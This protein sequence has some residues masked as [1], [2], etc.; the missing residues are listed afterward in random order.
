MIKKVDF[1][2]FSLLFLTIAII[3][4][5]LL[6]QYSYTNLSDHENRA[7]IPK[8]MSIIGT[9]PP[10]S[11]IWSITDY[12][13]VENE[14]IIVNGSIFI[15][16][17]GTLELRNTTLLMNLTSD[18]E[19]RI[20]VY[21][22]GNLTVIN[23]NITAYNITNNYYIKV[24][25]DAS[26]YVDSSEISYAGFG[27][28]VATGLLIYAN[29]TIIKNSYIHHN[30]VGIYLNANDSILINNILKNNTDSGIRL[31]NS[32][33]NIIENNSITNSTYG[34]FLSNSHNNSILRNKV[35]NAN[36]N[37]MYIYQS[38]N[39]TMSENIITN[40]SIYGIYLSQTWGN[41]IVKNTFLNNSPFG[42][43]IFYSKDISIFDNSI[44]NNSQHGIYLFRDTNVNISNNTLLWNKVSGVYLGYSNRSIISENIIKHNSYGVYLYHAN[45][46][47]ITKNVAYYNTIYGI[48]LYGSC[49]RNTIYENNVSWSSYG[50]Y[51]R[52]AENNTIVKNRVFNISNYGIYLYI[53]SENNVI[54]S[55]F[56]FNNSQYG[57]YIYKSS[58][59]TISN[60]TIEN[61][62]LSGLQLYNSHNSTIFGN[63]FSNN[64]N[65][66][67]LIFSNNDTI[68]K[69]K[70]IYNDCG[71]SLS[72]SLDNVILWN[73]I[74]SNTF[75]GIRLETKS[76]N[77]LISSNVVAENG[78]NGILIT[79]T[80]KDNKV[81]NNEIKYN[82]NSGIHIY[83]SNSTVIIGNI[84]LNN[85][86]YGT[87]SNYGYNITVMGNTIANNIVAGVY[88]T[89]T[90]EAR[91]FLNN[92]TSN[93]INAIDEGAN[94]FNDTKHGNYWGNYTGVDANSD[95][96][97]DTAYQ[98][99]SDSYD[100]YPLMAPVRV[101]KENTYYLIAN[102]STPKNTIAV[103]V[104]ILYNISGIEFLYVWYHVDNSER[105]TLTSYNS[106]TSTYDAE[107][108]ES[109]VTA[110]W[111]RISSI[112]D[113]PP[114]IHS[115]SWSPQVPSSSQD[116][117]IYANVTDDFGIY[118]VTLSYF[119]GIWN[120]VSM[121]LSNNIY[122]AVLPSHNGGT[123]ITFKI[124]V[125]DIGNNLV[126]S[127][128]Y[129]V[130]FDNPPIIYSISWTPQS[131][132][133]G[134]S[135]TVYANI[136]DDIGLSNVILSCYNG[137]WHNITMILDNG[138][139]TATILSGFANNT[140]IFKIYAI[141]T[142]NHW[143]TSE[144]YY[145]SFLSN[146]G[147]EYEEPSETNNMIIAAILIA[148]VG[149]VAIIAVLLRR[150]RLLKKDPDI[151]FLV[152]VSFE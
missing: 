149:F 4:T 73:N 31:F 126:S 123:I 92:F 141:D 128:E 145:I 83:E 140:I 60:N 58:N 77:T 90:T 9:P 55:N 66:L 98:I 61:N 120:N 54:T 79:D 136:T 62:H 68:A 47:N 5:P 105:Y 63:T 137:T 85:S 99:D 34:I 111:I 89:S 70:I 86:N 101:Y 71:L 80:S 104:K 134:Q 144:E 38:S 118:K 17:G 18:G 33:S 30:F 15:Q 2:H 84:I 10:S 150:H 95:L 41:E 69:N 97:G 124:Y 35:V 129:Q 57:V 13:V 27:W 143:T 12:T 8:A 3:M 113:N 36:S 23:S 51:L 103:K 56:V 39:N 109:H 148:I 67:L 102:L 107:I 106:A 130:T 132:H 7:I 11:G 43:G 42:I 25:M 96:I 91:V 16:N 112:L 45:Y 93:G 117:T 100:N 114:V 49:Q 131:P 59:S 142:A 78:K 146:A 151:H 119:D 19:F 139:Y 152:D 76:N 81:I 75:D 52:A 115:V 1:I 6:T 127:N 110:I 116:V 46:N 28:G 48:E 121:E 87:F 122:T 147:G 82:L 29:N 20:E 135:V 65:G 133:V 14:T 74:S 26:L 53:S 21:S 72:N 94:S 108:H 37:G 44:H 125:E 24:D 138:T 22:G 32:N 64:S 40:N 50:I 88:F